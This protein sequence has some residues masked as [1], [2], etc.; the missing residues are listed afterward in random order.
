MH[1]S[2]GIPF[3]FAGRQKRFLEFQ[4]NFSEIKLNMFRSKILRTGTKIR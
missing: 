3:I 4:K 1:S 2:L